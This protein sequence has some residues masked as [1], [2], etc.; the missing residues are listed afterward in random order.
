MS[1]RCTQNLARKISTHNSKILSPV[2]QGENRGAGCNCRIKEN[3][4]VPGNCLQKGV[5]YQATILREDSQTDTYIGQAATAFKDRWRNHTSSFRTRNPKNSRTLSKYVWGLQD[6]NIGF[7]I[8]WKIVSSATPYNH[9]TG[10]CR[11][12][13]R[14]KF[15]IIF[16]PEMATLN[17]RNEIAGACRHKQSQLLR[18][19]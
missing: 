2:E 7:E 6:Q 5:I 10:R 3:C 14:E 11:L 17:T 19:S 13:V 12:C 1:Y 15:F 9:V 18:K 8:K 4:P 16:K